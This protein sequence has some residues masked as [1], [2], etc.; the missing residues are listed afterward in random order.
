MPRYPNPLGDTYMRYRD[1]ESHIIRDLDACCVTGM[2]RSAGQLQHQTNQSP[3]DCYQ[4]PQH[5]PQQLRT[6]RA[7]GL[8]GHIHIVLLTRIGQAVKTALSF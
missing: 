5:E 2:F 1:L 6:D 8:A 7:T 4:P 3:Y